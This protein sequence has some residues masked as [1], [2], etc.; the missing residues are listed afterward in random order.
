[1]RISDWSSDVCSSDLL[2]GLMNVLFPTFSSIADDAERKRKALLAATGATTALLAPIMFGFWAIAEP[3]TA[4]VLGG[5]WLW[6]WPVFGLLAL[7]KGVMSPCGSFI[8][9]MKG[10]GRG[11]LLWW[12]DRKSTR[13]NSSH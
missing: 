8:P 7:A 10:M 6:L 11:D 13:L 9:F 5:K 2:V 3:V 4:I 12:L 1:M